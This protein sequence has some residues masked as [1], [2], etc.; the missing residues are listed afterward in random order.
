LYLRFKYYK[1][2]NDYCTNIDINR[3]KDWLNQA[4][5]DIEWAVYS[6]EGGFFSQTCFIAQQAGEKA[7]KAFCFKKGFDI[8]KTHSLHQI[9]KML[10]ENGVL[11]NNAKELDIYYISSRSPDSFPAGAPF[12]IITSDQAERALKSAQEIFGTISRRIEKLDE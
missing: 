3:Y 5:N 4:K 1:H 2:Q 11:E 8:V 9:I 10:K 7:L 12:E 6:F